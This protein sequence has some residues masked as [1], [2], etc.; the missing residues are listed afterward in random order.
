[1]MNSYIKTALFI[2]YSLYSL[3]S[4]HTYTIRTLTSR[5]QHTLVIPKRIKNRVKK[6]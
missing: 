2:L 4:L 1:M 5:L 6:R 3:L